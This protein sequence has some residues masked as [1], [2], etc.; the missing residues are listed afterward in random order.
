MGTSVSSTTHYAQLRALLY[1][2]VPLRYTTLREA[3]R[4]SF[5]RRFCDERKQTIAQVRVLAAQS[6][7]HMGECHGSQVGQ[8]ERVGQSPIL[9]DNPDIADY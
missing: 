1:R 7:M 5:D 2:Y 3:R 8:G 4:T 6:G 9:N